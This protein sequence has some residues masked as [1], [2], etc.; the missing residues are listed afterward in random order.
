MLV[1]RQ[2]RGCGHALLPGVGRPGR[3]GTGFLAVGALRP[4]LGEVEDVA[5]LGVL[6]DTQIR[7]GREASGG[8]SAHG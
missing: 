1:W 4:G 2:V 6:I 3:G 7:V 5:R 8:C